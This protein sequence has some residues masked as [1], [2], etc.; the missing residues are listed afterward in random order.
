MW[1]GTYGSRDLPARLCAIRTGSVQ[2]KGK[3]DSFGSFVWSL[4][5]DS[6]GTLWA[7]ADTGVWRL[8]PELHNVTQRRDSELATC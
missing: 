8:R 6:S 1:V 4:G 3:D 5:E 2:C 7:G